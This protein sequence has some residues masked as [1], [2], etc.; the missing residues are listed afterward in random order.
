MQS[1]IPLTPLDGFW[2]PQQA[3][4]QILGAPTE[5]VSLSFSNGRPCAATESN[6]ITAR[7][8]ILSDQQWLALLASLS[9]NRQRAPQGQA[10]WKR[11]CAALEVTA[12]NLANPDNPLHRQALQALPAYTGYSEAMIRFTL[13]ALDLISLQG[14]PTASE[15]LPGHRIVHGW[16]ALPDLSGYLRFYPTSRWQP[17]LSSLPVV[18]DQPLFGPATLPELVLG[19]GA[20][21]VPGTALLIAFLAQATTLA[22]GSP[23]A[24]LVKNSRREPIF[25]PLVLSAL[26]AV[27]PDL[28]AT[29]AV[30]IWDYENELL[31]N[32]LLSQAD[33]VIAAASDETITLIQSQIARNE[34]PGRPSPRFHAHGHKVSFSAISRET[35][36]RDLND[37][38][39]HQLLLD[40]ISLLTALDSAFWDQ[41]GCLSSRIHFV[42]QG[43]SGTYS[44]LEYAS[45][46][47][48]QLRLLAGLLPRGNWPRQQL[49][50]RFDRY[51]QLEST[52][53]VQVLSQYD[54]DFLVALDSRPLGPAALQSAVNDCQGRVI[55][56]RPVS[57]LMDIPNQYLRS[58]PSQNLQ[59]LSVA[60][61]EP[62]QTLN[63]RYLRFASACGKYGVTALRSAGRGAFPQLTHSWDGLIPLDLVRS[64][65]AGHFTTIEFERPC[66]QL[67]STYHLM[68]QRGAVVD[69]SPDQA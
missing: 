15:W 10:F 38:T 50:D 56:V 12:Q 4:N 63:T 47:E 27:D 3:R 52:G 40:I 62:G 19:Y 49:H 18:R 23:P 61:G 29:T 2:L 67:L 41:H 24:I 54:D 33:L 17:A 60:L 34:R 37:P 58:L 21:N 59:S 57:D 7:W 51:K 69:I 45:R 53:W 9:E 14:L 35:L 64:R 39:S 48:T 66:D 22:G 28:V 11:L 16:Q 55:L 46:L 36:R 6:A 20:G 5:F 65:P 42:E 44:P 13:S 68:Q 1:K 31:Q 8:P 32:K 30:L 43:D 25:T 26:E